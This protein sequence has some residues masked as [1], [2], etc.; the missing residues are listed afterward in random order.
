MIADEEEARPSPVSIGPP[1]SF[2]G[3]D[4]S[5]ILAL[6]DG[7]FAFAMTLLV[8]GLALPAGFAP[9][10][11]GNVLRNLQAAFLAYL[12][13]FFVI[14]LYW[15]AHHQIFQYI[16]RYDR[17][18]INLNVVFLL[19]IAVM[20]FVTNLLSAASSQ[21]LAVLVY[22]LTQI[23]AGTALAVLWQY[24]ARNRRLV[25]PSMPSS[26]I[27]YVSLRSA[28]SPVY[29]LAALPVAFWS[30]AYGEYSWLGLFLLQ[31]LLRYQQGNEPR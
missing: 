23:A 4:L 22:S 20:P 26:W 15:V 9:S 6:S 24:A 2:A 13:S 19:F 27:R 28:L 7:I 1:W 16:V 31:F 30:P 10:R 25:D 12:L 21:L 3:R 29:F 8:L 18:L 17:T 5:R 14:F 11:V